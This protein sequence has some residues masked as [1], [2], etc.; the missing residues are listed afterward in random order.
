[1]TA[2]DDNDIRGAIRTALEKK[3]SRT[4][5]KDLKAEQQCA[6]EAFLKGEDVMAILPTG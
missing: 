1:M 6:L 4:G 2:M 3:Q 5:I